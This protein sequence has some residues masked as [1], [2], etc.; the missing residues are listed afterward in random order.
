MSERKNKV[1][2]FKRDFIFTALALIVVGAMFIFM[3]NSSIKLICYITASLLCVW[4]IIK[5]FMYFSQVREEI[6]GSYGLVMSIALIIGGVSIFINPEFFQNIIAVFF[7]C[8][9][10]IDGVMKIQYSIDLARI[11]AKF[12]G[13]VLIAAVLMIAMG[14]IIVFNPFFG[15]VA[16]MIFSGIALVANGVSDLLTALYINKVLK[17]LAKKEKIITLGKEDYKDEA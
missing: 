5:L 1:K 16:F 10:I 6:F 11:G 17:S 15:A 14:F 12:W 4:G 9:L 8:V 7:G 13:V 2:T 3:P